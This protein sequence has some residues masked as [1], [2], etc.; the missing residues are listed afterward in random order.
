MPNKIPTFNP[1]LQQASSEYSQSED[2]YIAEKLFPAFPVGMQSGEYPVFGRENLLNVT[3]IKARA[4]GT[5]YQRIG[6]TEKKQNFSTRDYGLAIPVD[7]RQRKLYQNRLSAQQAKT[8]KLTRDMMIN[9]EIRARDIIMG[10]DLIP[11]SPAATPWTDP[12]ANIIG[13]VRDIRAALFENCGRTPNALFI[14]FHLWQSVQQNIDIIDRI[15][16]TSQKSVTTAMVAELFEIDNIYISKSNI[17]EANEGQA[18][19]IGSIWGDDV[20]FAYVNG[21]L[22]VDTPSLGRTFAWT[23][24]TPASGEIVMMSHRDEDVQSDII[25]AM[26]DVEENIQTPA[27]GYILTGTV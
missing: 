6:L 20:I 10:N 14:S 23:D 17:N 12:S 11:K 13:D 9:K 18:E 2:S 25:T 27:C 22:D 5:P 1:V 19:S 24:N 4:P 21:T 16:H 15:K 7:D 3:K 26:H 8:I